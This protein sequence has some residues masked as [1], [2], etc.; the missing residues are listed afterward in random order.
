[1]RAGDRRGSECCSV[2]GQ[3]SVASVLWT[4]SPTAKAG[5]LPRGAAH[6]EDSHRTRTEPC[7]RRGDIRKP[8]AIQ[9][10]DDRLGWRT[11]R[12]GY[13]RLAKTMRHRLWIEGR[14]AQIGVRCDVSEVRRFCG[15]C[16]S[17]TAHA[18]REI[19]ILRILSIGFRRKHGDAG[20]LSGYLQ[21]YG[22]GAHHLRRDRGSS[23]NRRHRVE[24]R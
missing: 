17:E 7:I 16:Q 15:R 20:C 21:R 8:V 19:V 23:L 6:Q 10:G 2:I 9:V 14:G 4:T 22:F 3:I 5:R 1:V 13:Q 11:R 12:V 24:A 18:R